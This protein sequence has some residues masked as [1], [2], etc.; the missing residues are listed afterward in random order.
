MENEMSGADF[1]RLVADV[2]Y[3]SVPPPFRERIKNV[4]LVIED[5]VPDDLRE[6]LGLDDDETLLGF[7]RGVPHTERGEW[8]GVGGTLPDVIMLFRIPI[9]EEAEIA[10]LPVRQVVEETIWHEVGHH[11]GLSEAE[12]E[13]RE[14]EMGWRREGK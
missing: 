13:R 12:V 9:L 10:G 5:D 6:E 7:Y 1:E 3:S 4:A 14:I 11:F 2:G 8:Y